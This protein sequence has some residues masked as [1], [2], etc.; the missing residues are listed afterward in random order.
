MTAPAEEHAV[1]SAQT[2]LRRTA[3]LLRVVF[4]GD[5][6][7]GSEVIE[8]AL[9]RSARV[10]LVA[11]TASEVE[12]FR[13][14][15]DQRGASLLLEAAR[16]SPAADRQIV[17][18]AA[19]L[20][21]GVVCI[22]D[23]R[24]PQQISQLLGAGATSCISRRVATGDFVAVLCGAASGVVFRSPPPAGPESELVGRL[25][26]RELEILAIAA[27]G[28]GNKQIA[29]RLWVTEQTIKFHLSNVYRKLDV[30]NRTEATRYAVQH[31]LAASRRAV[32]AG[33][34]EA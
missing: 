25:T 33:P 2:D 18:A 13:H 6:T 11:V 29:Q 31:G 17:E 28:T 22:V 26:K 24:Y 23:E 1:I 30:A 3:R 21:R 19:A 12:A 20:G 5:G 32:G 7:L 4:L 15:Q 27:E 34:S 9:A 14:L 8:V 16:D 10:E